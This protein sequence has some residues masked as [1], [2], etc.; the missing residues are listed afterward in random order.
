MEQGSLHGPAARC[1][2]TSAD[3]EALGQRGAVG[4]DVADETVRQGSGGVTG[5]SASKADKRQ[6][7]G[8]CTTVV[9]PSRPSDTGSIGLRDA[10]NLALSPAIEDVG[11]CKISVP[12]AMAVSTAAIS[13]LV[14]RPALE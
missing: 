14:S 9:P 11:P 6:C 12:P 10:R 8:I 4:N 3:L 2:I 1:A 13:G 7:V 5:R